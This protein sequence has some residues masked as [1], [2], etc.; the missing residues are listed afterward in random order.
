LISWLSF[1]GNSRSDDA[2]FPIQHGIA[3]CNVPQQQGKLLADA[4]YVGVIGSAVGG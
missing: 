3:D 2:P 4:L 1:E